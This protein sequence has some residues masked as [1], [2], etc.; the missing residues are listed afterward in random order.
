MNVIDRTI[1]LNGCVDW[2][3]VSSEMDTNRSA[4]SCF[5]QYRRIM[6]MNKTPE[7]ALLA[8]A[9]RIEA[10]VRTK[11]ELSDYA[12][13]LGKLFRGSRTP[14][15]PKDDEALLD[16][17]AAFGPHWS[18]VSMH[19]VKF[20]GMQCHIRYKALTQQKN[21]S[22]KTSTGSP[23]KKLPPKKPSSPRA[24]PPRAWAQEDDRRLFNLIE[25]T[26]ETNLSKLM[27]HFPEFTKMTVYI[28]LFRL[29]AGPGLRIGRWTAEEHH[30]LMNLVQ[31]HG[32]DDWVLI[33]RNM[34]NTKR[35]PVQCRAHYYF[36]GCQP[37]NVRQK[38]SDDETQRLRRLVE[39]YC[40]GKLVA[41]EQL[42][43]PRD[44]ESKHASMH[45]LFG[46]Q[47]PR[48]TAISEFGNS[49][50]G[51]MEDAVKRDTQQT[52]QQDTKLK[53]I[54]WP[55]I[56]SYMITRSVSQC[57]NKWYV[58][59]IRQAA[60]NAAQCITDPWSLEEDTQLYKL[61]LQAPNKWKWIAS[62]LPR[63]RA[64]SQVMTRYLIYVKKYVKMLRECRGPGWDPLADGFEEV[65]MRCEIMAWYKG[66]LVGYRPQ[67]SHKCPY[68]LDLNGYQSWIN[69][70][71]DSS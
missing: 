37:I 69:Q 48:G 57:R 4:S 36:V 17:V 54:P 56:A 70:K 63:R 29:R 28:A 20:S 58:D 47:G 23:S 26:G 15:S 61:Q 44:L 13:Y 49:L 5:V 39:L 27:P 42:S 40:Q 22:S 38:W 14:W 16:Y 7:P 45:K 18:K 62:S 64:Y 3:K 34:P 35:T 68:D 59:R 30:A 11:Y 71:N 8:H 6:Q 52:K 24:I 41:A 51:M 21:S 50:L 33:A 25:S 55:I 1:K 2:A 53:N 66:V 12:Y 46:M 60:T 31:Q 65:H 9:K 67:D 32:T 19:M 43:T 10:L